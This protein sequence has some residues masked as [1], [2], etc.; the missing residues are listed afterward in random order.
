MNND[1][2]KQNKSVRNVIAISICSNHIILN[3]SNTFF[4]DCKIANSVTVS[5]MLFKVLNHL[6]LSECF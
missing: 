5:S 2:E 6:Y 1:N 4:R 3:M